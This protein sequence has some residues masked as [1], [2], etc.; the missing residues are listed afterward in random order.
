MC[1]HDLISGYWVACSG[2]VQLRWKP[3]WMLL[4]PEVGNWDN[5]VYFLVC[6]EGIRTWDL[7]IVSLLQAQLDHRA[8]RAQL[9]F[10]IKVD[11]I[12]TICIIFDPTTTRAWIF[13]SNT[14][15]PGFDDIQIFYL[16]NN[17][18]SSVF[19][20]FLLAVNYRTRLLINE[21]III[22]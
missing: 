5:M 8:M 21:T 13:C 11:I 19:S 12:A 14:S 9:C 6:D 16:V 18:S 2:S 15:K 1:R 22:I 10:M 17:E 4:Y 3:F 20:P 7:V